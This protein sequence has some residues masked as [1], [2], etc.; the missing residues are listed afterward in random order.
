MMRVEP[1]HFGAAQFFE[2]I[3]IFSERIFDFM[4]FSKQRGL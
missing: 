4:S 1:S 2:E 3:L